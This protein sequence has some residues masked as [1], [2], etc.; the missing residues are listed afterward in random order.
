MQKLLVILF[1]VIF[2]IGVGYFFTHSED[3]V[4]QESVVLSTADEMEKV[5]DDVESDMS[6]ASTVTTEDLEIEMAEE[7]MEKDTMPAETMKKAGVYKAYDADMVAS[8]DAEH[9]LLFFHAAWCPSCRALDADIAQHAGTIPENVV[10][11]KV[12]Y[13]TA[14]DLKRKY[15]ITT[16][17]SLIEIDSN[18]EAVG[19]ISHP[20]T[21]K[22]VLATL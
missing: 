17:H 7:M 13:D 8:N 5:S 9:T 22:D 20:R 4:R 11:Y 15:G 19:S 16:Q 12:D 1:V 10:I 14:T 18:G 21:L 6:T 3:S 2:I